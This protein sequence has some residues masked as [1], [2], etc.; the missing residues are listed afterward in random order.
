MRVF[1]AVTL[2]R[3][4]YARHRFAQL[5]VTGVPVRELTFARAVDLERAPRAVA[6]R[7]FA[8]VLLKP[9]TLVPA[10]HRIGRYA[11]R[12]VSESDDDPRRL[13]P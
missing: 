11:G 13:R 10:A 6:E 2:F 9:Q 5:L 4:Q 12:T 7:L 1:V 3:L 8:G